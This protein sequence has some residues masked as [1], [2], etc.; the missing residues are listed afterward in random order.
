MRCIRPSVVGLSA[1]SFLLTTACGGAGGGG[2]G[3]PLVPAEPVV[4]EVPALPDAEGYV[5]DDVSLHTGVANLA[6][7]DNALDETS[8]AVL[9]FDLA[10]LGPVSA[11][12]L[13]LWQGTILGD[14][15]ALGDLVLDHVD[16]GAGLDASDASAV[17]LTSA[18]LTLAPD[19]MWVLDVTDLV[20][21]DVAAGRTRSSFRLRFDTP[22]DGAADNDFLRIVS[23]SSAL[24]DA[25]PSL[26]VTHT[27]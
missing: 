5:I 15:Y 10:G 8:V 9:S 6:I 27:P 13:T 22:T 12:E 19:T 21:A 20:A 17:A 25:H 4:V 18:A 24:T 1:L 26:V 7:G 23:S 2:G 3:G 14:P 11:A 16:L